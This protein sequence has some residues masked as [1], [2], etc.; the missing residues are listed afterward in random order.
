MLGVENGNYSWDFILQNL[1]NYIDDNTVWYIF[2]I[3]T[4]LLCV[5]GEKQLREILV[6]PILL[7][8][9]IACNPFIIKCVG[10]YL[11]LADR[12]YRFFWLMSIAPI[13][14]IGAVSLIQK[15]DIKQ[16]R[17]YLYFI[18]CFLIAMT[19]NGAYIDNVSPTY[20]KVQN[21]YC[22][23]DTVIE[24]SKL[25]H[26]DGIKN[27]KVLYG[28]EIFYLLRQ[29]DASIVS[30]LGRSD[31]ESLWNFYDEVDV[32]KIKEEED[33]FKMLKWAY[34]ASYKIMIP[35]EIFQVALEKEEVDYII[36][37]EQDND[38]KNYYEISGCEIIGEINGYIVYKTGAK[39]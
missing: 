19:G 34:F 33:Y 13:V 10:R 26:S 6:Y 21:E 25:L 16:L 8:I 11:G 17:K 12:Y 7:L 27:P 18:L 15:I 38:A 36:S 31:I 1:K 39:L 3:I 5:W 9:F 20:K 32:G 30:V 35:Q 28:G 24:L 23:D 4:V 14:G 29:Y 22:I 37:A 2:F